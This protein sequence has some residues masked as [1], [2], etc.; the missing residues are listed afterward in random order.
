MQMVLR[1]KSTVTVL[2]RDLRFLCILL[3]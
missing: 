1:I 3:F 2:A